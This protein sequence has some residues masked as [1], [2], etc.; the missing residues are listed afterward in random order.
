[1]PAFTEL[2]IFSAEN[3][4]LVVRFCELGDAAIIGIAPLFFPGQKFDESADAMAELFTKFPAQKNAKN[5]LM[6]ARGRF[7]GGKIEPALEALIIRSVVLARLS[8]GQ[9]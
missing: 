2:C 8:R 1:M 7:F 3:K 4:S 6:I 5:T 9:S